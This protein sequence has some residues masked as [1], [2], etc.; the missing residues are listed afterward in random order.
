MT[1]LILYP[2]TL[3]PLPDIA[4]KD[5]DLRRIRRLTRQLND[6]VHFNEQ[7]TADLP[8]EEDDAGLRE[9]SDDCTV[10]TSLFTG[11]FYRVVYDEAYKVK[12]PKTMNAIAI[13]KLY[14]P[15]K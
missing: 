9:E 12:N 3:T 11:L 13:E 5:A 8:L 2:A 14:A 4:L 6:D 15:K 1:P 10:Y 7:A